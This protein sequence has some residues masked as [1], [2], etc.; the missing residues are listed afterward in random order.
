MVVASALIVLGCAPLACST[1]SSPPASSAPAAVEWPASGP[2]TGETASS[3]PERPDLAPPWFDDLA[4][5][6]RQAMDSR[7]P[8]QQRL[9]LLE[10]GDRDPLLADRFVQAAQ[11]SDI[12]VELLSMQPPRR[13]TVVSRALVIVAG[14][15]H[16][17][18]MTFVADVDR[19]KIAR[20]FVC[21][22]VLASRLESVA[23]QGT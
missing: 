16:Y 20:D 12:I 7:V 21:G 5:I 10:Y 13:G 3:A 8:V 19:W 4:E 11:R 14:A 22:I 18:S 6:L 15:P 9:A 17:R 23:C 2:A 1:S